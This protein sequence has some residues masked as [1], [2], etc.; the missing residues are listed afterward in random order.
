MS[1]M[2]SANTNEAQ[3]L[4]PLATPGQI[5]AA[6]YLPVPTPMRKERKEGK[7]EVMDEPGTPLSSPRGTM[8]P[9]QTPSNHNK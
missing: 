9:P 7:D 5:I 2:Q 1:A 8:L 6:S 3:A 4:P